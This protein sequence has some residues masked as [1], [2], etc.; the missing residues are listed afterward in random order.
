MI[1]LLEISAMCPMGVQTGVPDQA[2]ITGASGVHKWAVGKPLADLLYLPSGALI[3]VTSFPHYNTP[4]HLFDHILSTW[5]VPLFFFFFHEIMNNGT[6]KQLFSQ[7]TWWVWINWMR[8]PVLCGELTNISWPVHFI[9]ERRAEWN[10]HCL[11]RQIKRC[12][13]WM[14][15]SNGNFEL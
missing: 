13:A 1:I 7:C 2:H 10:N 15:E 4:F 12:F 9:I 14:E 5:L 11:I 6:W 8:P 3:I